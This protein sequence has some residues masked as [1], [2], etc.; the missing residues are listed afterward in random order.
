MRKNVSNSIIV[1]AIVINLLIVLT[2]CGTRSISNSGYQDD[3]GW[4]GQPSNP[5]Y[6]GELNELSVLGISAE[7]AISEA[8]IQAALNDASAVT[9]K[10][11]DAILLIQSGA[12]FPDDDM[13]QAMRDVFA[14]TPLS[15]VPEQ[16]QQAAQGETVAPPTSLKQVLRLSAAQTGATTVIVYWG[17][18]E[19]AQEDQVTKTVSWVPIVGALIPDE[20]QRMRIRLKGVVMDVKSGKWLMLTPPEADSATISG[21]LDREAADQQQVA[22]MKTQAYQNFMQALRQRFTIQ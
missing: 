1:S 20:V 18:I 4:Y 16:P 6:Q 14:V 9:L 7:Q 15:G 12:M 10:R 11:G 22:R 17:I 19:T 5:F 8:D 3:N 2:G 21:R 13:L